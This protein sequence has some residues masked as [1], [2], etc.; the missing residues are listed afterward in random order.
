MKNK[1]YNWSKNIIN[2]FF[3]EKFDVLVFL[4]CCIICIFHFF[5]FGTS[6]LFFLAGMIYTMV[7]LQDIN[8]DTVVSVIFSYL[9]I[10]VLTFGVLYTFSNKVL[11]KDT[12]TVYKDVVFVKNGYKMIANYTNKDNIK[13][14]NLSELTWYKLKELGC[15]PTKRVKVFTKY[16]DIKITDTTFQCQSE[17]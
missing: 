14:V 7:R 13:I 11:V 8:T 10:I 1:F 12:V 2:T 3:T 16:K 5:T 4:I 17:L 6:L 15:V 9:I